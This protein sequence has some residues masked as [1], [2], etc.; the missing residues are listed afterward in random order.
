MTET[1][2]PDDRD[3]DARTDRQS[4][5]RPEDPDRPTLKDVDHTPPAGA[6]DANRVFE[7]GGELEAAID[8]D[9]AAAATDGGATSERDGD[10]DEPV[11]A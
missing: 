7:R 5:S 4:D 8:G 6:A 10:E 1:T 3:T 11:E 2:R 9:R